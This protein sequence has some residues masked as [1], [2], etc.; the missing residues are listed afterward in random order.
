[1]TR[2]CL[3]LSDAFQRRQRDLLP[4]AA[5]LEAKGADASVPGEAAGRPIFYDSGIPLTDPQAIE[6]LD[7]GGG[8]AFVARHGVAHL[9]LDLGPAPIAYRTEQ[10]ANGFPRY[11]PVGPARTAAELLDT[12][13]RNAEGI[14]ARAPA[15]LG[16]ENLNYFPTGAYETVC[17]PDFIRE[18]VEACGLNLVLDLPHAVIS[19]EN[20]RLPV[21]TYLDRLPLD[22]VTA[23][24]ISRPGVING[25]LEDAHGWLEAEDE[26]LL[27][28]LVRRCRARFVTLEVYRDDDR[29]VEAARRLAARLDGI[30]ADVAPRGGR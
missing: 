11:V 21:A 1:M 23:I 22:S 14:R 15:Q 6:R 4:L 5:A 12:C 18:V 8:W 9:T 28:S 10:N 3:P 27:V 2:L 19:A 25:I 24:H 30:T 13:R 29:L 17:E 20:L 7:R 16:V 26:G